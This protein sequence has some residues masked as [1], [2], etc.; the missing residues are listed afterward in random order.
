MGCTPYL[1]IFDLV[2]SLIDVE[3]VCH[4]CGL[5]GGAVSIDWNKLRRW[6]NVHK[7]VCGRVRGRLV[8]R[9]EI[10]EAYE[11]YVQRGRSS[12]AN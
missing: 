11:R 5:C 7:E 8:E 1:C 4:G 12:N 2:G 10:P 6:D 3:L 9:K